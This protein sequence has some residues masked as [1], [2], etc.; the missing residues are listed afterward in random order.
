MLQHDGV[1]LLGDFGSCKI[2]AGAD[3]PPSGVADHAAPDS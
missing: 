1:A 3:Q 2:L